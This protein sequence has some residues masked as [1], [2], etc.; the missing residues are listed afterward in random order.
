MRQPDDPGPEPGLT[1]E[2]RR[3][4]KITRVIGVGLLAFIVLY[5][6]LAIFNI[7]RAQDPPVPL[8]EPCPSGECTVYNQAFLFAFT[9]DER[10]IRWALAQSDVDSM[11]LFT[12]V[13]VFE[14]PPKSIAFPVMT[15][16]LPEAERA[17]GWTPTRAGTY[18][19]KARACRVDGDL[20]NEPDAEQHPS[21]GWILCSIM[22][23]SLDPAH[24]DPV[25]Y[26]RGFVML[27]KIPPATGGGIE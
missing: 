12:D 11:D 26:P 7:V 9:G 10:M 23:E 22:I 1:E 13:E 21:R 4:N 6:A 2:Q 16:E 19:V 27:I 18:Y 3:A 25:V 20:A 14:F 15:A 8:E 5:T 17:I 24:T